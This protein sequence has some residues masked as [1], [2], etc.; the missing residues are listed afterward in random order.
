MDDVYI[1]ET[2]LCPNCGEQFYPELS[3]NEYCNIC[4]QIPIPCERCKRE[5]VGCFMKN[6]V[7]ADCIGDLDQDDGTRCMYCGKPT[8]T[9]VCWDCDKGVKPVL[10]N[11]IINDYNPNKAAEM[12]FPRETGD[13]IREFSST[14]PKII[15]ALETLITGDIKVF[16]KNIHKNAL[17]DFLN[18]RAD[19]VH[20][21]LEKGSADTEVTKY[22]LK[23][24]EYF[25]DFRSM[26]YYMEMS[27]SGVFWNNFKFF[28]E[29]RDVKYKVKEEEGIEFLIE[30]TAAALEVTEFY[31]K[32][33][34]KFTLFERHAFDIH[35]KIKK[36]YAGYFRLHLDNL[37]VKYIVR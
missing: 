9:A 10:E 8:S 27:V 37:G 15:L 23:H 34:G 18:S 28:L 21:R 3:I 33:P 24:S 22:Y 11:R 2:E 16:I 14:H 17:M 1:G 20:V 29:S 26:S 19:T 36:N 7:C 32:N 30:S 13:R 4:N 35:A 31:M 6:G 12:I 25:R 5:I